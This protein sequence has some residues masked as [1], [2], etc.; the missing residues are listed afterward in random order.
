MQGRQGSGYLRKG[1]MQASVLSSDLGQAT[2]DGSLL[3]CDVCQLL[4]ELLDGVQIACRNAF[5][6]GLQLCRLLTVLI[7]HFLQVPVGKSA[8]SFS[9]LCLHRCFLEQRCD[10]PDILGIVQPFLK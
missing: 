9:H 3:S 4:P 2:A 1:F 5:I 8:S 6:V 7:L 10:G